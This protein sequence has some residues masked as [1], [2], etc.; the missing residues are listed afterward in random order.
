MGTVERGESNLSF[1][2][3]AR[4]ATALGVTLSALFLNLEEKAKL[5]AAQSTRKVASKP[6]K[7]TGATKNTPSRTP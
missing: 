6:K 1:Q 4:V 2:N 7:R 5:L 3:I